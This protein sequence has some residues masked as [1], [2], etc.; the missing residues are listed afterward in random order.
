M[1]YTVWRT[2]TKIIER[3]CAMPGLS[4]PHTSAAD[5]SPNKIERVSWPP[6]TTRRGTLIERTAAPSRFML[7]AVYRVD[8][9][10]TV[11]PG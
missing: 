9:L 10:W 3:R 1:R 8:R 7:A 2:V 11:D 5:L 6:R 4:T